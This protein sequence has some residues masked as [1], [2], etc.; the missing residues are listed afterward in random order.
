MGCAFT[1]PSYACF[2]A[3]TEPHAAGQFMMKI[4]SIPDG[5]QQPANT[6]HDDLAFK[7]PPLE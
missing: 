6:Q 2:S 7:V 1:H 4:P 5:N 3:G